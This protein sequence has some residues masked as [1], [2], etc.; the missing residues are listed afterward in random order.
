MKV[1][2]CKKSVQRNLKIRKLS[3]RKSSLI[4]GLRLKKLPVIGN[5]G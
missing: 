3:I 1:I 4:G 2:R 5:A